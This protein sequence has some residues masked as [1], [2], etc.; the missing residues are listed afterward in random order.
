MKQDR[1][2]LYVSPAPLDPNAVEDYVK[3]TRIAGEVPHPFRNKPTS[4]ESDEEFEDYLPSSSDDEQK[5]SRGKASKDKE[6]S[7]STPKRPA[8]AGIIAPVPKRARTAHPRRTTPKDIARPS[9]V[10]EQSI[11]PVDSEETIDEVCIY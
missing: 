11:Q 9:V 5:K 1:T 8:E 10:E 4:D 7:S 2:N 6:E 3:L